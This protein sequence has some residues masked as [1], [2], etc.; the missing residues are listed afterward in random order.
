MEK[1]K[2]KVSQLAKDMG[3]TGKVLVELLKKNGDPNKK[4]TTTTSL[5]GDELD[6]AYEL[7]T[8]EHSVDSFDQFL[9]QAKRMEASDVSEV[10]IEE[11]KPIKNNVKPEK[12]KPET[13]PETR[14]TEETKTSKT[15]KPAAKEKKPR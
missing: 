15:V 8:K 11:N 13:K 3:M 12:S 2:I 14:K 7:I 4:Y 6:M 1:L 5:E 9:S 10:V